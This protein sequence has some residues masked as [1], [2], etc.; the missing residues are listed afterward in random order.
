MREEGRK[1][2]VRRSWDR[3]FHKGQEGNVEEEEA[4]HSAVCCMPDEGMKE[5]VRWV[6]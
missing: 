2:Q 4:R 6:E 1:G 5:E 3:C